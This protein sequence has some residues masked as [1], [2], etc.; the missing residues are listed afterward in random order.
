MTGVGVSAGERVCSVWASVWQKGQPAAGAA[1]G[2]GLG[3]PAA[4]WRGLPL[5]RRERERFRRYGACESEPLWPGVRWV[6]E[7]GTAVRKGVSG[8]SCSFLG[9]SEEEFCGEC[10]GQNFFLNTPTPCDDRARGRLGPERASSKFGGTR[11]LG[12]GVRETEVRLRGSRVRARVWL[13]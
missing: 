2:Q 4:Q 6:R 9:A 7:T 13:G 12:R 3:G 10:L 5:R 8:F 11:P 1:M